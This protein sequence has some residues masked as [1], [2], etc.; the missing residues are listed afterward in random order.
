MRFDHRGWLWYSIDNRF[1]RSIIT[2][3]QGTIT[4]G[5]VGKT[6]FKTH[7][8]YAYAELPS[9]IRCFTIDQ[10][11]AYV[12]TTEGVYIVDAAALTHHLAYTVPGHLG[13]GSTNVEGAGTLLTGGVN[14]IEDVEVVKTKY[15]SIQYSYLLITTQLSATANGGVYVIR[16]IDDTLTRALLYPDT[17]D[18]GL[19]FSIPWLIT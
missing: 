5:P 18:M 8:L 1:F 17:G 4:A 3:T 10:D 19:R 6:W 14:S 12:G 15:G 11:K 7:P 13:H 2:Y 9:L 16:V